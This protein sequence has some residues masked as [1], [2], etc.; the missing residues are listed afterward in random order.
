MNGRDLVKESVKGG[1]ETKRQTRVVAGH[2]GRANILGFMVD[3][4]T[5]QQCVERL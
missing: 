1:E 4:M 3:K 2:N 5:L